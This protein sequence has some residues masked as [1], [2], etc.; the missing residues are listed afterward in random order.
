M[1]SKV[2]LYITFLYPPN[3]L[4]IDTERKVTAVDN[5]LATAR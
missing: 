4:P 5:W 1:G 3:W 2:I